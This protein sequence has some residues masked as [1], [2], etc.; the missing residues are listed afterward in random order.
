V[1]RHGRQPGARGAQRRPLPPGLRCAAGGLRGRGRAARRARTGRRQS[2]RASL[3]RR[4]CA[5]QQPPFPLS[6]SSAPLELVRTRLQAGRPGDG[7][8][9]SLRA[10]LAAALAERRGLG[11]LWRGVGSTLARDVPF[12]ALY[13]AA[14]EPLRAAL[15]ALEPR[16]D[17][18]AAIFRA[19]VLAGSAAGAAAAAATTPLDAVKTLRMVGGGAGGPVGAAEALR[20]LAA[21]GRLFVGVLPRALRAAPACGIVLAAYELLQLSGRG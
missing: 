3:A 15:L 4:G 21:E 11:A 16:P 18:P 7:L 14:L 12:S 5:R 8:P 17:A 19:N 20:A 1:A 13:W 6:R 2:A 9:S 10:G